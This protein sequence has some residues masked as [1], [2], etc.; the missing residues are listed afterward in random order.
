MT[1][2]GTTYTP[3]ATQEYEKAV[4]AAYDGPMFEGPVSMQID[5]Y[6]ES[7]HVRISDYES[8]KAS[9]QGDVDNYAKSI[10]D[11][12]NKVAYTD[13]KLV[14]EL[15]VRKHPKSLSGANA[16]GPTDE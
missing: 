14:Y 11:A 8:E 12:L 16:E 6:W 4:A 13:D 1:K 5:L 3:K 7:A 10:S 15:T 2:G 9:L